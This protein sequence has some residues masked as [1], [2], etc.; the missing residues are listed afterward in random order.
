MVLQK[1]D[2]EYFETEDGVEKLMLLLEKLTGTS[3]FAKMNNYIR[4]LFSFKQQK[5]WSEGCAG[6]H[7]LSAESATLLPPPGPGRLTT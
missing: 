1:H 6:P 3:S 5:G 2:I 4:K 7:H